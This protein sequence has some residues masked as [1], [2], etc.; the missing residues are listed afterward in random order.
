MTAII[1]AYG[2]KA[3]PFGKNSTRITVLEDCGGDAVDEMIL[4]IPFD[5]CE[6]WVG[7]RPKTKTTESHRE[8][9][10]NAFA[11]MVTNAKDRFG[12]MG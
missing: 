11:L 9:F 3:E 8:L 7:I 2:I 4:P 12:R 1:D 6:A 5:E 10:L